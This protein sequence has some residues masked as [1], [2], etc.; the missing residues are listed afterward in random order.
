MKRLFS[1]LLI[2]CC[3][4]LIINNIFAQTLLVPK[5]KTVAT[6]LLRS[7]PVSV[8]DGLRIDFVDAD[9]VF[10]S[11]YI[12]NIPEV[13]PV[14]RHY[15]K[16][17]S[18]SGKMVIAK[19]DFDMWLKGDSQPAPFYIVQSVMKTKETVLDKVLAKD[20]EVID[21]SQT[22]E[23]ENQRE[24]K[25]VP[26]LYVPILHG[27][28]A[29]KRGTLPKKKNFPNQKWEPMS[30]DQIWKQPLKKPLTSFRINP[31][32]A[33][34]IVAYGDEQNIIRVAYLQSHEVIPLLRY[35]YGFA[36][37]PGIAAILDQ[38]AFLMSQK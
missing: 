19:N 21:L 17:V 18:V 5:D 25:Y 3:L 33:Q 7:F 12:H 2:A 4:L 23:R 22:D 31:E 20:I 13:L 9:I 8:A 26:S 10:H 15:F 35:L 1:I 37:D 32:R 16:G 6:S 27:G 24:N 36:E 34:W 14:V 30:K 29:L 11:L 38:A 28:L